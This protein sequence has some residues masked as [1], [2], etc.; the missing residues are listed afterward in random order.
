MSL[1]Y[2]FFQIKGKTTQNLEPLGGSELRKYLPGLL[3]H[4]Y[5]GYCRR[6]Q[7]VA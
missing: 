2:L 5:P 6:S 7:L 1:F 4:L 3:P